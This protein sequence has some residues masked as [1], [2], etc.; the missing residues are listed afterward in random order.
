MSMTE[1]IP[2][3]TDL[4]V[5]GGITVGY[6]RESVLH[7]VD[8]TVGKAEIVGLFGHNGAGKSTLFKAI[9]GADVNR[10]GN[11]T[12][13]G[14]DLARVRPSGAA[15]MGIGIVPQGQGIFGTLRVRENVTFGLDLKSDVTAARLEHV[16][17][18]LPVVRERWNEYAGR[19]S[20][21][22]RQIVSIARALCRSPRLLLLDEPSIGLAPKIV[23]TVMELV[24]E[25][26]IRD[27]VSVLLAEQNIKATVTVLDR[28]YIL[29]NGE[30]VMT[31]DRSSF[32]N[33]SDLM[34]YF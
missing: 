6:G 22:Q 33:L 14:V 3:P 19:L 30:V 16:L 10:S 5:L 1:V 9:L 13:D 2:T 17:E 27:G 29:R 7:H 21:G 28:G 32:G 25:I 15:E 18:L 12:F 11:M 26:R 23:S 4:L 8:L 31:G 24:S 34:Q 20:G